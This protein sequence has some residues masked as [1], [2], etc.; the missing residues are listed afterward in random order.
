MPTVPRAALYARV[1]HAGDQD[2]QLQ[3]DALRAYVVS[4]GWENGGEYV[5]RA[6]AGHPTAR[7]EWRR[8]R[9]DC[10][11]GRFDVLVVWKLDRAFRSALHALTGVEWLRRQKVA[12]VCSSQPIDTSSSVG[13][14]LFTVL[15]AVAEMERELISER[16]RAGLER[17]RAEG[18]V[19]GRPPGAKDRRRRRRR[20]VRPGQL[21][22]PGDVIGYM[23]PDELAI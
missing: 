13:R 11:M 15:A 18:R 16:T 4:R 14:L 19:L 12:F 7:T 17:A 21:V 10:L 6:S 1:S 8:L 20:L 5:D 9:S 22:R 2:P 23:P 3:L